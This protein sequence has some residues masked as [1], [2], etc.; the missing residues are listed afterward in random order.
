MRKHAM[1]VEFWLLLEFVP[2]VACHNL[3]ANKVCADGKYV[4]LSG[5]QARRTSLFIERPLSKRIRG[6][7]RTE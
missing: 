2:V 6:E 7:S 3:P 1:G 4:R 5:M